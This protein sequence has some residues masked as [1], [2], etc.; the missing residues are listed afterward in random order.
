MKSICEGISLLQKKEG[1]VHT[2]VCVYGLVGW[3]H[4]KWFSFPGGVKCE[5]VDVEMVEI[6]SI[7]CGEG[8]VLR[9]SSER[10]S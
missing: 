8:F 6:W 2:W 3:G 10:L 9:G 5:V 4:G 1:E 7:V